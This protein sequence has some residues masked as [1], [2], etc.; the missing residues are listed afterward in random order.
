MYRYIAKV[1]LRVALIA[2]LIVYAVGAWNLHQQYRDYYVA[3]VRYQGLATQVFNCLSKV[4][5]DQLRASENAFGNFDAR[6]FGCLSREEPFWTNIKEV[7]GDR[8]IGPIPKPKHWTADGYRLDI[9]PATAIGVMLFGAL[10]AAVLWLV[11]WVLDVSPKTIGSSSSQNLAAWI[12][13][14]V[15]GTISVIVAGLVLSQ[16]I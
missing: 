1:T 2:P 12:M 5:E 11:F 4:P 8:I 9:I 15:T 6:K 14:I 3:E 7:R 10:S 16:M 13:A